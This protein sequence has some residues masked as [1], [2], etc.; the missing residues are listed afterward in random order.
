MRKSISLLI[1]TAFLFVGLAAQDQVGDIIPLADVPESIALVKHANDYANAIVNRDFHSVIE[2]THND[3]VEMGGGADY[4]VGD[5]E[6]QRTNLENQ[7]MKYASAEVGSH[8]EF[9][10]SNG[11]LQSVIPLKF[12]MNMGDKKVESWTN[13]FAVSADEGVSWKFVNLEMFDDAS[14]REFV[15]NVSEEFVYPK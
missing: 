13:L 8:P 9:L 3:V 14:L 5:L 1:L 15:K 7:G 11:E 10:N 12:H 4:M 6:L 2:L